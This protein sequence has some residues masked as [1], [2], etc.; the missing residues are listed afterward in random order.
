[1]SE[2]KPE[3]AEPKREGELYLSE[4]IELAQYNGAR[5]MLAKDAW[6]IIDASRQPQTIFHVNSW[7]TLSDAAQA[8]CRFM[9]LPLTR[10]ALEEGRDA[11]K[12]ISPFTY[13]PDPDI[14]RI[15]YQ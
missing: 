12:D 7:V 10:A 2:F 4:V 6:H 1:M 13:I 3:G 5:F 11:Y 15:K 8:Y 14:L 9:D